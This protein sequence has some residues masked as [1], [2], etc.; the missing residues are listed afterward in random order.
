LVTALSMQP[1]DIAWGRGKVMTPG[2]H[3]RPSE[4]LN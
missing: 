1:K 3:L 2:Q 4:L